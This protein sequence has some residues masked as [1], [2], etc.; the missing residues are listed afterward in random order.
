M[1]EEIL[2]AIKKAN[3]RIGEE[4]RKSNAE[5]L[6]TF[7]TEDTVLLI[8]NNKSI[9][10]R[11]ATKE[12]WGRALTQMGLKDLILET[13]EVFGSG[14][15]VTEVGNYT[16]KMQP[17]GQD[18]IEDKGK[19]LIVWKQTDEGLKLHRDIWNSNFPTP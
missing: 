10:G 15:T 1:S 13:V 5:G 6:A 14:E 2:T 12:Y 19:Y 9:Y 4:I 16:L 18:P 8:P 17:E 11:K 3:K 7:Y